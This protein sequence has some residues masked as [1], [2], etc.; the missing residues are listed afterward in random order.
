[1]TFNTHPI[2]GRLLIRQLGPRGACIVG[3]MHFAGHIKIHEGAMYLL[4]VRN[5][6]VLADLDPLDDGIQPAHLSAGVGSLLGYPIWRGT[7]IDGV[8]SVR[9]F[10]AFPESNGWAV[11]GAGQREFPLQADEIG[12]A[13]LDVKA[14]RCTEI[15]APA[16]AQGE[17]IGSMLTNFPVWPNAHSEMHTLPGLHSQVRP[18]FDRHSVLLA[19]L[20]RNEITQDQYIETVRGD[21]DLREVAPYCKPDPVYAR[22]VALMHA[23]GMTGAT[24]PQSAAVFAARKAA[25]DQCVVEGLLKAS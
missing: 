19:S 21:D 7:S 16:N 3:V 24:E 20:G 15:T 22:F 2:S 1:M 9:F 8:V 13:W 14:G 5:G 17:A 25:A 6:H 4:S 11:F 23:K 10:R 12:H 18:H